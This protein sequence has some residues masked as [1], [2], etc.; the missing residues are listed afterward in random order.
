MEIN[1]MYIVYDIGITQGIY[2]VGITM[3]NLQ[4]KKA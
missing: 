4:K 1:N 2:Y 3:K